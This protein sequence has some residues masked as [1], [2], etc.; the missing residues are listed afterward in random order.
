MEILRRI[1]AKQGETIPVGALLAIVATPDVSN[2]EIDAFVCDFQERF[3]PSAAI[4][5]RLVISTV[6]RN[7]RKIQVGRAGSG[8]CVPVVLLHGYSGDLNNWTLNFETLSQVAPVIAIDLPGHGGSTKD[9]DDGSLITLATS[10]EAT[11]DA[12]AVGSAHFIG[13]SLGAAVALRFAADRPER[14]ASLSLICPVYLPGT[15]LNAI[16]LTGMAEASR[17]RDLRPFLEML[18]DE[19]TSVTRDMVNEMIK[20]KRLDGVEEALAVLC[21]RMLAGTDAEALDVVLHKVESATVIATR[22]DRT[23]GAP[24]EAALPSG[25]KV[26]WI[27]MAAHMP[28]LEM[29]A[30]INAILLDAIR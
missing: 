30:E 14:V 4:G 28:H 12:L 27:E 18:F 8:E 23:V 16:F 1:V 11:L 9:V 6:D 17:A 10:V 21:N 13:H 5:E 7:G 26:H 2:A 20:Y 29:A 3:V 24:D 19:P 22:A 15:S 25:F